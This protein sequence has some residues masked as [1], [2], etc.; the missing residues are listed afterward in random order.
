MIHEGGLQKKRGFHLAL[1]YQ[2]L[3]VVTKKGF[4][5]TLR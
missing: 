4:Y 3:G 1:G 2:V 5:D